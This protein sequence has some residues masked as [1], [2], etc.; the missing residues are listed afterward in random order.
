M[1]ITKT[2]LNIMY[3]RLAGDRN[4]KMRLRKYNDVRLV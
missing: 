4:I 2:N 1:N 3:E